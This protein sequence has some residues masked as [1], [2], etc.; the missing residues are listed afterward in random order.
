MTSLAPR[1]SRWAGSGSERGTK[2]PTSAGMAA[3]YELISAELECELKAVVNVSL[4]E[5][6]VL[7]AIS[8]EECAHLSLS[9]LAE[10]MERSPVETATLVDGLVGSGLLARRPCAHG[11]GGNC[12]ELTQAGRRRNELARWVHDLTL[13]RVMTRASQRP[14]L[15]R[16]VE[17]LQREALLPLHVPD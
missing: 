14:S 7:I 10:S 8:R 12:V 6:T 15:A 3:F 1:T 17:G 11:G 16:L 2:A 4:A 13:E 9:E 5:F